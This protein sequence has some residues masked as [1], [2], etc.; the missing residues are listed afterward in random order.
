MSCGYEGHDFG[1][2]YLDSTCIDGYLWDWDSCDEPGGALQNGGDI[3]CPRCNTCE[4]LD[5]QDFNPSGSAKQRRKAF[6]VEIARIQKLAG[7]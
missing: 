3:P 5:Y 2:N 7:A 1:A 4:Y 6:R